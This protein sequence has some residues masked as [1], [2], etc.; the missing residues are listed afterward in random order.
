LHLELSQMMG[1]NS[2]R[3]FF[4][5]RSNAEKWRRAVEATSKAAQI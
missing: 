3:R 5:E 1:P 2:V 4:M